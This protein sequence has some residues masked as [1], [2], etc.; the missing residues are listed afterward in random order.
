MTN[1]LNALGYPV[2]R[3]RTQSL[4]NE[5]QVFVR[6]RLNVSLEV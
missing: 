3:R 4:M 1:A 6:C 5:A 2:G